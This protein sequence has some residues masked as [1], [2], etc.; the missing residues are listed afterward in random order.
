MRLYES[1]LSL[2]AISGE[3][4]MSDASIRKRL[5]S[6]GVKMRPQSR[7]N[8]PESTIKKIRELNAAGYSCNEIKVLCGVSAPTVL[9]YIRSE[10]Q[11][12]K[13]ERV[14]I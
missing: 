5:L 3:V 8:T 13:C 14:G 9:K 11:T 10:T 7:R 1:G 2:L 12:A 6:A 4:D